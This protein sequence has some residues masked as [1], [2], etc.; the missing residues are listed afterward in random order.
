MN[1]LDTW[2]IDL[3]GVYHSTFVALTSIF[4]NHSQISTRHQIGI[5]IIFNFKQ[6][7]F[8]HITYHINEWKCRNNLCE[9]H[10]SNE[11]LL[12]WFIML[13]LPIIFTYIVVQLLKINKEAILK[14]KELDWIYPQHGSLSISLPNFLGVGGCPPYVLVQS[15]YMNGIIRTTNYMP[16]QLNSVSFPNILLHTEG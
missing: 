4:L 16:N 3:K 8:T 13:L 1:V 11:I 5:E 2:Y 14:V 15:N 10:M 12:Y 6:P 9:I 7:T